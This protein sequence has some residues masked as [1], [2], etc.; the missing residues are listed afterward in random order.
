MSGETDLGKLLKSARPVLHPDEFVFCSVD[1]AAGID[2]LCT[3]REPEGVTVICPRSEAERRALP[4]TF[5]CRMI[6]LSVQSSLEAVGF[7]AAIAA[8]LTR[9]GIAVNAVSA[10]YHDHLFVPVADA[11]RALAALQAASASA[12]G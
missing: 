11:A 1:D 2:A 7:L 10:Y 12:S 6:T 8:E 3:F 4:F 5:R 9:Q